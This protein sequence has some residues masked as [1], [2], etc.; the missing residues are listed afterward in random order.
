MRGTAC[1]SKIIR[2]ARPM[3]AR[4]H[5]AHISNINR[6]S[7]PFRPYSQTDFSRTGLTVLWKSGCCVRSFRHKIY[8][9]YKIVIKKDFM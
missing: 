5:A 8:A 7:S 3:Q 1:R 6:A 9:E 2:F 4:R